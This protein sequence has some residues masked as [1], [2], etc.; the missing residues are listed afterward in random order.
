MTQSAG[1]PPRPPKFAVALAILWMTVPA[2]L[3]LTLVSQLGVAS[4]WLSARDS[5]AIVI[6]VLCFALST[7]C[8]L[9]PPYAQAILAGWTFGAVEGGIAVTLGLISGA[10][11]GWTIARF[12]S[13]PHVSAWIDANPKGKIIRHELVNASKR[14]TFVL[15]LL[16]RLPPNSPFAIANLAMGASGVRLFPL[17]AA[18]GLGMLPRTFAICSAS[19]AAAATGAH[20]IQSL[21]K[22]QGWIWFGVGLACLITALAVIAAIAR[23]ALAKAGLASL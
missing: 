13:G 21:I 10:A 2:L 5:D 18:T 22:E 16:L 14:R 23:R 20:D 1:T 17:L 7:G 6:F 8:G 19:A 9:L 11:I 4:A 15:L 3:G 12:A